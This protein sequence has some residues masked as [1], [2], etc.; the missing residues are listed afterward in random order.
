MHNFLRKISVLF[1]QIQI[2][3]HVEKS[4]ALAFP[5]QR[6]NLIYSA[7]SH[8]PRLLY[9]IKF[10]QSMW[11]RHKCVCLHI[12]NNIR[13]F[14][15]ACRAT[16]DLYETVYSRPSVLK[17]THHLKLF[18]WIKTLWTALHSTFMLS[19]L[20]NL[21][22]SAQITEAGSW[23]YTLHAELKR[24]S[25]LGQINWLLILTEWIWKVC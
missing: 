2:N 9:L 8:S 13:S 14:F 4:K 25:R 5:R 17:K 6:S 3:L 23:K 10:T 15:S 20:R 18:I 11:E 16:E 24:N 7:L 19:F 22:L 1:F 12:S 21:K